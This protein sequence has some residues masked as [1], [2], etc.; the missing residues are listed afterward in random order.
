LER[1]LQ[2]YLE[3]VNSKPGA[4]FNSCQ[5]C[6][7]K[8][9]RIEQLAA[10]G[11][12]GVTAREVHSHLWP[13]VDVALT[14]DMPNQDAL[15][16]AIE[17]CEFQ[18]AT[19]SHFVVVWGDWLPGEPFKFTVEI[20]QMA[21]HKLPSGAAQDRRLWIE[22]VAYDEAG[23]VVLESG[24]IADGELEEKPKD[25]PKYDPYFVPFRDYLKDAEGR[26]TH[27]FWEAKTIVSQQLLAPTKP[28]VPHVSTRTFV[29]NRPMTRPPQR[30]EL[31]L[32]MRPM[33][34]DVLQDLVKS[35][36][37]DA[38]II[39]AMPT[40]TVTHQEARLIPEENRYKMVELSE[41]DC[42]T[43]ECMLDPTLPFC[44]H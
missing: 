27:M 7:M 4:G 11:Y 21:G 8:R 10:P 32:R 35:G 37:L 33:G 16:S 38:S 36:H 39:D 19:I 20:E 15:R 26:D 44:T 5:G 25:H 9:S 6:H 3:S 22:L 2:E 24:K 34:V 43:F 29:T 41:P 17:K 13:G 18:A 42:D 1:T 23:Q 31:R 28:E 14:P 40:F 30:I 12:P